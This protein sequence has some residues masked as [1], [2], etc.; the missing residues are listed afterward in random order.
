[1]G[2]ILGLFTKEG[3]EITGYIPKETEKKMPMDLEEEKKKILAQVKGDTTL[4][5]SLKRFGA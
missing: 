3:V 4:P 1:L 2:G 5:G